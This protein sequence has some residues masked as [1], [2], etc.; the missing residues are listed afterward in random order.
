MDTD[1]IYLIDTSSLLSLAR[2]YHPFD[3][4]QVIT[5]FIQS[6]FANDKLI[7]L[8]SVHNECLW[9]SKKL[10]LNTY[11]FLIKKKIAECVATSTQHNKLANSWV[12]PRQKQKLTDLEFETQKKTYINNADFQLI[13]YAA[14]MGNA[15]I[16]TE[17]S[18][19]S[20]DNKLFKKIP[21]IC[22][23]EGIPCIN[24]TAW[25]QEHNF[26]PIFKFTRQ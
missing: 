2:Y 14:L 13:A 6:Q 21:A 15:T 7:L 18:H 16:V 26:S 11:P 19:S 23:Q 9:V 4:N 5:E 12:V 8:P 25:L 10:V 3:D 1:N 20:N 24:L 22:N 17:E